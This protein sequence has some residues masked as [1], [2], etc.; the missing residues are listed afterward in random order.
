L[1]PIGGPIA[2]VALGIKFA[3]LLATIES[4]EFAK[5]T[6]YVKAA[7]SSQGRKVDDVPAMLTVG[8]AVIPVDQNKKQKG[9]VAS[10]I[11]G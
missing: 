10:I 3:A 9:L 5:G 2:A 1:G 8:E 4:Q 11:G 6:D 7:N